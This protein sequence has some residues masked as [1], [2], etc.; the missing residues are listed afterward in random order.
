[1]DERVGRQLAT[2]SALVSA[3]S[4]FDQD[5]GVEIRGIPSYQ[6][7]MSRGI[8]HFLRSGR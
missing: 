5:R 2:L 1:M 8:G 4:M 7:V 6:D 3:F